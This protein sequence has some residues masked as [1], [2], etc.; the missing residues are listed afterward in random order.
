MWFWPKKRLILLNFKIIYYV[1][2]LTKKRT[3]S[4]NMLSSLVTKRYFCYKTCEGTL[5]VIGC[6]I[7]YILEDPDA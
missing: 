1:S 7:Y 6:I 2:I 3:F 5:L 4:V